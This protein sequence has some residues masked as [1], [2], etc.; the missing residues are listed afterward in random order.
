MSVAVAVVADRDWHKNFLFIVIRRRA[1]AAAGRA[2]ALIFCVD[3][4]H[5]VFPAQKCSSVYARLLPSPAQNCMV[6]L[7]VPKEDLQSSCDPQLAIDC[8]TFA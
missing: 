2:S 1:A 8:D 7:S 3:D 6:H 5:R 4:I